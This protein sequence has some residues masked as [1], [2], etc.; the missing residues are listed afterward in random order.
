MPLKHIT[1]LGRYQKRDILSR[2]VTFIIFP[3]PLVILKL[4]DLLPYLLAQAF[5]PAFGFARKLW[6]LAF[7]CMGGTYA[8][9]ERCP[10]K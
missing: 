4:A 5:C 3:G 7:L 10:K 2:T 8:N 6:I 9:G 1:I